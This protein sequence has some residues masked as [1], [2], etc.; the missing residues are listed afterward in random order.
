M[1]T[2]KPKILIVDD[3][4]DGRTAMAQAL[5]SHGY[6]VLEL[7]DGKEVLAC[8]KKEWP[9]LIILDIVL[10]EVS[11]IEVLQQLRAD[12]L[13]KAIPVLLLTA[14]PD[15]VGNIPVFQGKIDRYLEKPGSMENIFRTVKEMVGI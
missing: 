4:V 12:P 10:P 3:E 5:K 7:G 11:G 2:F 9:T 13:A 8:A 14:K 1:A 6:Q 15:V